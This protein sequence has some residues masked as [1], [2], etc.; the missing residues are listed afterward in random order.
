VRRDVAVGGDAACRN[1]HNN[2]PD[3]LKKRGF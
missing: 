3:S 2:I 1:L